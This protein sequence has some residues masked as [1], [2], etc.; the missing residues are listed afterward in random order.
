MDLREKKSS[1]A[2]FWAVFGQSP[3]PLLPPDLQ[4]KDNS[5]KIKWINLLGLAGFEPTTS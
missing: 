1:K 4:F 5:L 3:L 2:I